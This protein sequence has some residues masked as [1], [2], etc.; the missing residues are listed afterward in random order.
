M[1]NGILMAIHTCPTAG[2]PMRTHREVKA[3][4]G[5]GLEGDRYASR[6]GT[7][8]KKHGPDREVTLI[9]SEALEAVARETRIALFPHE[10]RRNLVTR[11]VRL[12]GLVGQTFTVGEVTL[13]GLRLCS[14]CGYLEQITGKPIR[15]PL[16]DRGGLRARVVKGGTL[17]VGDPIQAG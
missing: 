2:D 1:S 10:A 11:G 8:S 17:R 12:N 13:E 9:E 4:E 7:Y 16:E 15:T 6:T 3:L 5:D 14:P